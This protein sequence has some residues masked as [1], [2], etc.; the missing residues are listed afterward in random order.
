[1]LETVKCELVGYLNPQMDM[2]EI[3]KNS[4]TNRPDIYKRM[5]KN[6]LPPGYAAKR[7]RM[8]K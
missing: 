4:P 6:V 8:E 3:L 7:K 1:M 5:A 2:A